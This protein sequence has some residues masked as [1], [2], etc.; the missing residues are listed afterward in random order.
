MIENDS[1]PFFDVLGCTIEDQRVQ[2]SVPCG[3]LPCRKDRKNDTNYAWYFSLTAW[4]QPWLL[5]NGL[6]PP[7]KSGNAVQNLFILR[8]GYIYICVC[9]CVCVYIY[10]YKNID[11]HGFRVGFRCDFWRGKLFAYMGY[12]IPIFRKIQWPTEHPWDMLIPNLTH[13]VTSSSNRTWPWEI[14][15]TNRIE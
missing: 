4:I 6:I 8:P 10:I 5:S 9:V 13:Y 2:T 1:I 12:S 11:N 14:S 7:K 3:F 15:M